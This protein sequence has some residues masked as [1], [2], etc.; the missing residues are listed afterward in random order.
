MVEACCDNSYENIGNDDS[1]VW[2]GPNWG[3]AGN[4]PLRMFK[5]Y[6]S[7]G[8]VNVPAFVHYPK[9]FLSGARS[10]ALLSVKDVMPTLLEVAGIDH[11]GAGMFNGREIVDMQGRSMLPLLTGETDDIR[12]PG[13]Y[14]GWEL[15][16]KRAIRQGNWKIT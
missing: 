4:V 10:D 16:G 6:T 9:R 15:F 2:Y 3:Q 13:D 14:L 1:Y 8:G 7:Q 5:G 12:E 11:P